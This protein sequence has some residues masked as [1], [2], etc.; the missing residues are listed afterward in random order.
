VYILI[1]ID[2]M[3]PTSSSLSASLLPLLV[4]LLSTPTTALTFDCSQVVIGDFKFDLSPL[5]GPHSV[6]KLD[7]TPVSILNTTFTLD[8]CKPLAKTGDK[9]K[10]PPTGSRGKS[11][12][13]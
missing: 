13:A 5:G 1:I 10:D 7:K 6:I 4:S 11:S 2:D 3:Y 12:V 8:I 9:F